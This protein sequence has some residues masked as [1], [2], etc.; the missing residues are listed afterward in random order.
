LVGGE[1]CR[2]LAT[3]KKPLRAMVRPTGDESRIEE[4]RSSGAEL[5]TGDLKDPD[6][7]RAACVGAT[8]VL[9][10]ASSMLSRQ[11]GDTIDGVD[12]LG[13]LQLVE[14]AMA[15]GAKHFVYVSFSPIA[16]DFALQRAK[17]E[18]EAAVI[19]S[20]MTY[21]ILRP[22][23]FM[24]IWL[25]KTLGFDVAG[26]RASI[27]GTGENPISWIS[28]P[29][30]AEFA[31]CALETAGARNTTFTL[32]GPEA[33]T[34]LEVVHIFEELGGAPFTV[35]YVLESVL[36]TGKQTARRALDEAFAALSVGYANGDVIDMRTTLEV[37]PVRLVSV[38]EY[39]KWLLTEADAG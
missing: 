30:V 2:Y 37:I 8:A 4:L 39:A 22:T 18:V 19:A 3:H 17:R 29:N 20:G 13:Q 26:R 36:R 6:S 25:S 32:G 31:V 10:T 12:R 11:P 34:P 21:T 24:E 5:V 35:D 1:I 14:A 27:Y 16:E 15:A 23:F 33:L 28:F 38:R 7:V 9:S